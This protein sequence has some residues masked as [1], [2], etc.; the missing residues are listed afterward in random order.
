MAYR[1]DDYSYDNNKDC[2]R[3]Y[4]STSNNS[5]ESDRGIEFDKNSNLIRVYNELNSKIVILGSIYETIKFE[6][7]N[8][9]KEEDDVE[10]ID[11]VVS[12]EATF[13]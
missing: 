9:K 11:H 10:D 1:D 3:D 4:D 13:Y 8:D 6:I 7:M 5:Y 2:D 12:I